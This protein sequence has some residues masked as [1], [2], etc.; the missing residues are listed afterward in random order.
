M[1]SGTEAV[2]VPPPHAVRTK[3]STKTRVKI[4]YFI[5]LLLFMI[6]T[7]SCFSMDMKNI[8]RQ[9]APSTS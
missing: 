7:D 5:L 1:L 9:V 4:V 2:G 3:V 6:D 8:V